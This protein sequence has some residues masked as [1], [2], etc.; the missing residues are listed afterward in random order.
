M[1]VRDGRAVPYL[2]YFRDTSRH[3]VLADVRQ[4]E[5]G[6]WFYR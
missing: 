2:G 6:A 4:S 1:P 5:Q 3:R